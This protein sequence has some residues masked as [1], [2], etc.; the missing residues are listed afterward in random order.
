MKAARLLLVLAACD[1]MWGA[2]VQLRGPD[3]RPIEDATVAVACPDHAYR[4]IDMAARTKRDGSGFVGSIGGQFPV[5]CDVFIAKPG[6]RTHHIK[7]RDLCP[8]G[9]EHCDRV[10]RFDLVLEPD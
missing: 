3:R 5:G 7:Y 6:F 8:G 10:F 1:P 2:N 9:P 4:A